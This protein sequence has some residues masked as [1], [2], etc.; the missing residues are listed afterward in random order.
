MLVLERPPPSDRRAAANARR[1]TRTPGAVTQSERRRRDRA[2]VWRCY[3]IPVYR[4]VLEAM[5]DRG[6]SEADSHNPKAVARE[7]GDVLRQ[8]AAR[9]FAEKIP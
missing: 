1:Q 6:L 2:G 8:W 3:Q 4:T 9:W 5:I 7:A